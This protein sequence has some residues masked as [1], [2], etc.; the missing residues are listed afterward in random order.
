MLKALVVAVVALVLLAGPAMAGQ[1]PL[2]LKQLNEAVDKMKADDAKVKQAKP[3][4]AEAQKLHDGGNHADS[5]KK[6]D[7]AAKALGVELKKKM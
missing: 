1:C 5:V 6:C 2:L 4:I 7:E 3:L